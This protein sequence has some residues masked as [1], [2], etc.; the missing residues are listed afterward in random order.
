MTMKDSSPGYRSSRLRRPAPGTEV[1]SPS[2]RLAPPRERLRSAIL[3]ILTLPVVALTPRRHV[4]VLGTEVPL[5]YEF[6]R[7]SWR[8][9]RCVEVGLGNYAVGLR[10]PEDVLEV[11]NVLPLAGVRG[12]TVVDKYEQ[13]PDVINEDI[14][15]FAP[16]SRYG[17]IVSLSTL[18]HVGWDEEPQD[19][20]KARVALRAMSDLAGES[21]QMLVT[22][23]IGYHRQLEGYFVS[24]DA[25]FDDVSLLVKQSRLARWEPRPVQERTG[26][27]Y[28]APYAAGNAILV[29][30]RGNPLRSEPVQD[31]GVTS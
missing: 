8:N 18:E 14:V 12:H 19:P 17:L 2:E 21:G 26:I 7:W 10:Q 16:S 5:Y 13:G 23:P 24:G 27:G 1:L 29:G 3:D 31:V 20:D 4:T 15:D 30:T 9:E 6:R 28:G 25:P 11:G 22:I